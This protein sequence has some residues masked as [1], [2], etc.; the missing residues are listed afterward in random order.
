MASNGALN[1][2]EPMVFNENMAHRWE[3]FEK[4]F[5][6]YRKAALKRKDNDEITAALLNLAGPEAMEIEEQFIYNVEIRDGEVVTQEAEDR[7][8]PEVVLRKFREY[9]VAKK[10]III[11]RHKF[12]TCF[13]GKS[14][15]YASYIQNLRK[16]A[17]TCDYG[18]MRDDMIR[19][20]LVCANKSHDVIDFLVKEPDLTL[21]KAIA[22]CL[23]W[24]RAEE[25]KRM[26]AENKGTN[27]DTKEEVHFVKGKRYPRKQIEQYPRK[28]IG[29]CF[30]CG[31]SHTREREACRAYGKQCR[32]CKKM[33]HFAE[34]CI[35][36]KK[37]EQHGEQRNDKPVG[38]PNR[39]YKPK[40]NR[41]NRQGIYEIEYQE[42]SQSDGEI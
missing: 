5:K 17:S 33:N 37:R 27:N 12:N 42:S 10:N 26:L 41:Q 34:Y 22:I 35:T 7:D 13:Q 18:D 23:R 8:N 32:A 15:S 24:E 39:G 25:S 2:V 36:T 21:A 11:E 31:S 29:K 28:Q 16:M 3:T 9:C 38:R 40:Y 19:D 4:Q 30:N 14:E 20:R 6:I 1:K